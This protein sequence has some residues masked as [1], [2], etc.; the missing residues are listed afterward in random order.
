MFFS[1]LKVQLKML[2]SGIFKSK[3]TKRSTALKPILFG[4]LYLFLFAYLGVAFGSIFFILGLTLESTG[5]LDLYFPVIILLSTLFGMMGTMMSAEKLLF[6]GKD[7]DL[8]LS[9]PIPPSYILATRLVSLATLECA[10]SLVVLV[11]GV[12]SFY[13]LNGVTLFSLLFSPS[14]CVYLL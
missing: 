8:L 3:N 11:P 12:V 4:L 6:E 5:V 2:Y 1:L 9:M 13:I 14:L 10:F 7:N